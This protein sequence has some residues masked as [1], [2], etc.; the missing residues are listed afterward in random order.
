MLSN[1]ITPVFLALLHEVINVLSCVCTISFEAIVCLWKDV[2]LE[3]KGLYK[4]V[5]SVKISKMLA[6]T[7]MGGKN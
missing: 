4:Y 2:K 6:A 5:K 7:H 1:S 3:P